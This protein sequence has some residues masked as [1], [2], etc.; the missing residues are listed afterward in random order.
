MRIMHI[1]LTIKTWPNKFKDLFYRSNE[2]FLISNIT[3]KLIPLNNSG[4][5][6]KVSEV[7]MLNIK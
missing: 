5:G 3:I 4:W 2:R 6:K 1:K 7:F